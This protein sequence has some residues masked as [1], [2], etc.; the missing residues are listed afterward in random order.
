MPPRQ[1]LDKRRRVGQHVAHKRAAHCWHRPFN[2]PLVQVMRRHAEFGPRL[3]QG[4]MLAR[5]TQ[6]VRHLCDLQREALSFCRLVSRL[7]ASLESA[8]PP[9]IPS[10]PHRFSERSKA[11]LDCS[12]GRCGFASGH[13]SQRRTQL[14]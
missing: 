9:S 4:W 14:R 12:N 8:M 11:C 13:C 2:L 7:E 1:H 5:S 3:F 10:V 6:L